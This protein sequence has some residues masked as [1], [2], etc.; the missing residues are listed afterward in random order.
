MGWISAP[1]EEHVYP[2]CSRRGCRA[3]E[4]FSSSTDIFRGGTDDERLRSA[5]KMLSDAKLNDYGIVNK[6]V[7]LFFQ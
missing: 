4:L 6:V 3:D 2:S 7:L 5:P 1:V